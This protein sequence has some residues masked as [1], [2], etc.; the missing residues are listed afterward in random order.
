MNVGTAVMQSLHDVRMLARLCCTVS[1]Y[2][3]N[4]GTDVIQS[5]HTV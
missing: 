3:M 5:L 4:V 1:T 2:C